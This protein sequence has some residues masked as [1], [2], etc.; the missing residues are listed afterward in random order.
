M[1]LCKI[2]N[3]RCV[4]CRK[5][6]RSNTVKRNCEGF[7]LGD[8]ISTV[9]AFFGITEK[10]VSSA[11]NRDCGCGHRKKALNEKFRLFYAKDST[12]SARGQ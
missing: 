3:G 2:K 7:G 12:W 5:V 10:R 1:P 11:L 6:V 4:Y 9:L 8:L